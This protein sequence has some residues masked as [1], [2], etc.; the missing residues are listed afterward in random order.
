PAWHFLIRNLQTLPIDRSVNGNDQSQQVRGVMPKS[1]DQLTF[2]A[3]RDFDRDRRR[4]LR[5]D[6]NCLFANSVNSPSKSMVNFC[7]CVRPLPDVTRELTAQ[8]MRSAVRMEIGVH[9]GV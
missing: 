7:C 6:L 4:V 1:N 5:Y 2:A 9:A 3:R 8:P